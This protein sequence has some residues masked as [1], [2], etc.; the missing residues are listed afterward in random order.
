MST[1]D[2]DCSRVCF[3]LFSLPVEV[4]GVYIIAVY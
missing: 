2:L 4:T 1:H 3:V